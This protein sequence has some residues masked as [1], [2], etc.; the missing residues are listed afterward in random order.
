[1]AIS[2]DTYKQIGRAA[3]GA[4]SVVTALDAANGSVVGLTVS[5]FVTLSFQPPLVMFALQHDANSYGAIVKGN[6]FGVS[7]LS[8]EQAQIAM[9]FATKGTHKSTQTRFESGGH[10]Q[11]PL[12]PGALA[13]LECVKHEIII[14]GDHAIVVGLVEAART[15][16]GATPL[17]YYGRRFGTFSPLDCA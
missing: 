3:A 9:L 2:S 11:V 8:A 10:L 13:Q 16:A 15:G 1:V 12:I 4:V 17:L 5:S 7:L 6:E 14:A